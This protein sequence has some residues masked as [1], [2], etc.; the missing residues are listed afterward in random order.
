MAGHARTTCRVLNFASPSERPPQAKGL[1]H[2]AQE[3]LL[4]K[5]VTDDPNVVIY[6]IVEEKQKGD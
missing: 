3:P 5:I 4:M 1:P 6:W 2:S